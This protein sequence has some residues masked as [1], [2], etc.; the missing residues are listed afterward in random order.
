M[1]TKKTKKAFENRIPEH[2]HLWTLDVLEH[3]EDREAALTVKDVSEHFGITIRNAYVRV[4][5]LR[6]WGM[7]RMVNRTR[8]KTYEITEWGKKFLGDRK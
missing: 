4:T 2:V 8:P 1:P 5:R 3:F 7:V 6:S